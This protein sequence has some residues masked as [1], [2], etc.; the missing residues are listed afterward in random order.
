LDGELA[1][2]RVLQV[3]SSVAGGRDID[4][5][6]AVGCSAPAAAPHAGT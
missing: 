1:H 4:D 5:H 6:I 3:A 2:E